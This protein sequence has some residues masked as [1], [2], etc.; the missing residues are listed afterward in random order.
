[1]QVKVVLIFV[2]IILNIVLTSI[3]N[4]CIFYR[5]FKTVVNQNKY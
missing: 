3:R 1:M 5:N 2:D 4:V